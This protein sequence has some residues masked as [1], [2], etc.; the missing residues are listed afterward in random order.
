MPVV[1]SP[2][3]SSPFYLPQNVDSEWLRSYEMNHAFGKYCPQLGDEVVYC[4]Q[5]HKDYLTSI[6]AAFAQTNEE[7]KTFIDNNLVLE[8]F[9]SFP[10]LLCKVSGIEYNFPQNPRNQGATR[11]RTRN[12]EKAYQCECV[13]ANL[14]LTILAI[15]LKRISTSRIWNDISFNEKPTFIVQLVQHD[16]P[17]FLILKPVFNESARKT[18][19]V[20]ENVTA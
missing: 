3:T 8:E 9:R 6:Q 2:Q 7:I 5:G 12:Q 11:N 18:W 1:L 15:P 19:L 14:V 10:Y 16:L 20:N 13:V 17:D 4:I